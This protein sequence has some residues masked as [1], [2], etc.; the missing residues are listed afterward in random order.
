M[1]RWKRKRYFILLIFISHVLLLIFDLRFLEACAQLH[2]TA[3]TPR[4]Y[5]DAPGQ[6]T[7]A[8]YMLVY[9]K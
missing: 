5:I 3:N 9:A 1:S 7:Y 2:V 8:N 4:V 6:I